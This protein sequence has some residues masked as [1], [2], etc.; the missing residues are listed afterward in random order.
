MCQLVKPFFQCFGGFNF[1]LSNGFS[2]F[3]A[4]HFSFLLNDS[5]STFAIHCRSCLSFFIFFTLMFSTFHFL[6]LV[7]QLPLKLLFPLHILHLLLDIYIFTYIFV[8]HVSMC[9]VGYHCHYYLV[10]AP[11]TDFGSIS[12]SSCSCFG[13]MISLSDKEQVQYFS[14]LMKSFYIVMQWQWEAV[15]EWVKSW[16]HDSEVS[17]SNWSVSHKYRWISCDV[18]WRCLFWFFLHL[19]TWLAGKKMRALGG[20]WY[21]REKIY[22]VLR[23]N[24]TKT[25]YSK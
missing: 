24:R 7:S 11:L 18:K 9:Y 23:R 20:D 1:F 22:S 5:F 2:F 8:I 4:F 25:D 19:I 15:A 3:F 21:E 17:G 16:I 10:L 6:K 12:F 13:S 14:I